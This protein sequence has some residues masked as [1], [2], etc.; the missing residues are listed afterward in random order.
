M[1]MDNLPI[2]IFFLISV[3]KSICLM[4]KKKTL[5]LAFSEETDAFLILVCRKK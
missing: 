2:I 4:I 5:N 3:S 1:N